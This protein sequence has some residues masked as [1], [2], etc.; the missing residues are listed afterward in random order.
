MS[1]AI[2]IQ[3]IDHINISTKDLTKSIHFY[4]DVLGFDIREDHREDNA[5]YVIMGHAQAAFLAIHERANTQRPT[6]PFIGHWGLVVGDI[7]AVRKQLQ[8]KKQD[9]L[10]PERNNGLIIYPQSRSTY[11]E[12]PDGHEIE[13]VENFAGGN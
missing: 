13:L 2:Q 6:Q 9:W 3:A 10:Y 8:A 11:I 5:P 7:D 1:H 12:D 4:A